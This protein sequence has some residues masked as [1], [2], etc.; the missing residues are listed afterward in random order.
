MLVFPG[1]LVS[2]AERGGMPIPP[3]PE[4]FV[5]K[6]FPHFAVFCNAQLGRPMGPTDHWANAKVVKRLMSRDY[7]LVAGSAKPE[8]R[9]D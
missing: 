5:D 8:V 2:A 7:W 4:D 6:D 1:M 9:Y 3:D